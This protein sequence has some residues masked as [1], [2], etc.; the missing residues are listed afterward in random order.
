M[1]NNCKVL[2]TNMLAS[3]SI[4]YNFEH[5]NNYT[6][7]FIWSHFR[8]WI[9][10]ALYFSNFTKILSW[11]FKGVYQFNFFSEPIC[12]ARNVTSHLLINFKLNRKCC[13]CY[14]FLKDIIAAH[15]FLGVEVSR[16]LLLALFIKYTK[17]DQLSIWK[18][19]KNRYCEMYFIIHLSL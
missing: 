8:K 3:I 10:K 14:A 7:L 5:K 9:L 6:F 19:N 11:C 12:S 15:Q 4:F 13:L 18:P 16:I 17:I 1:Q 2:K